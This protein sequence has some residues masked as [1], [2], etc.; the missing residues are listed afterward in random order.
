MNLYLYVHFID[1]PRTFNGIC[2][3]FQYFMRQYNNLNCF[4]TDYERAHSFK[5]HLNWIK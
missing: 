3:C 4:A 1:R 2:N 5:F